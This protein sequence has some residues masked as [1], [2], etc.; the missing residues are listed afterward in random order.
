MRAGKAGGGGA[1]S[2][3]AVL[4]LSFGSVSLL[5]SV[6]INLGNPNVPGIEHF[7]FWTIIDNRLE[8]GFNFCLPDL[9]DNCCD[10]IVG[11]L[12]ETIDVKLGQLCA[13]VCIAFQ[14]GSIGE[15]DT[16]REGDEFDCCI[17]VDVV[18]D[19]INYATVSKFFF[20]SIAQKT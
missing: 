9:L 10:A 18:V 16:T 17:S 3:D 2:T 6:G 11:N 14:C 4:E 5:C 1:S 13:F 20:F 19:E 15:T 7:Q 12:H 8:G